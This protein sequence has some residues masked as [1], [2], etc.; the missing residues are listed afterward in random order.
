MFYDLNHFVHPQ[1]SLNKSF[2]WV[3]FEFCF[4]EFKI[5]GNGYGLHDMYNVPSEVWLKK[6]CVFTSQKRGLKTM[7]VAAEL[8]AKFYFVSTS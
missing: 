6:T 8:G 1:Q 7:A 4:F 3:D 2:S 5:S